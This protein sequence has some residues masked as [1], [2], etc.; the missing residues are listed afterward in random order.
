[1][2]ARILI[3]GG[4][5][6]GTSIAMHAARRSDPLESPV[7][8]L[9]RREFGAGSSGRSGAILRQ[10]YSDRELI[11]MARDSLREY[12]SFEA[13]TGRAIG[14]TRCGVLTLGGAEK[15][16]SVELVERNIALMRG[17][18]VEVERVTA[19]EMRELVPGIAIGDATVGA[20]ER[21]SGYVDPQRT[22]DAFAAL[23]RF[24]GA[25]LRTQVEVRGFAV[26][27]GRIRGV[28]TG[29]GRVEAE[30]VVVAAGPWTRRLLL[31]AGIDLPLRAVRPE[32]H[33][34]AMP[35]TK[36]RLDVDALSSAPGADVDPRFA[37]ASEP[38]P[39]HAVLLDLERDYYTRCEPSLERT[40]VG[41]MDYERDL[42][43]DD[44]DALDEHVSD[45]FRRWARASLAGRMPVYERQRDLEAQAAWYTLTPDA[46]A[47]IGACPGIANLFVVSGFSGH[48]FKLAPSIGA[49]VTQMLL[50]EPVGA[51][52][53]KFFAPTRFTQLEREAG[54]GRFGL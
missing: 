6:M 39:A 35:P 45:E 13:R 14:F 3:V 10:F 2:R 53:A 16:G 24:Y 12:A 11:G 21:A 4:G 49:G 5:V 9:E 48:G 47:L 30:L 33:F 51:F 54:S 25:T 7:V 46:Q 8:L 36:R 32:Q 20:W 37:R 19:R 18:G 27:N 38:A 42:E 34:L 40:R 44:P 50:G 22:V 41:A 28:E 15:P 17:C 1:M 43:L 52:D 29:D 31:G 26:E 23:A